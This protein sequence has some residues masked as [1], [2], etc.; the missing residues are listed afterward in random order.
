ME[1]DITSVQVSA[2]RKARAK[3]L[4]LWE[5]EARSG[6]SMEARAHILEQAAVAFTERGFSGTTL[7]HVAQ[8]LGATKGQIYHYYRSKSDLYFDVA[9][10]AH[11]MVHDGTEPWTT[12]LELPPAERLHAVAL[13]HA[14]VII[15]TW[16]WQRVA[17][18]ATQHQL[19]AGFTPREERALA[20]MAE[21]RDGHESRLSNIIAEGFANGQF[22]PASLPFATKAVLGSLNWLTVWYD[23][24]KSSGTDAQHVIAQQIADFIIAGLQQGQP[25]WRDTARRSLGLEVGASLSAP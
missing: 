18:E 23:P 15:R 22:A 13:S 10:G 5:T 7:D 20:R 24:R 9:V 16:A 4:P 6:P 8:R 2:R 14:M 1:P 3:V 21:F 17:L 25:S 12:R 19:M 11:F